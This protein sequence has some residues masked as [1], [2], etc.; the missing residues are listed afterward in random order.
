MVRYEKVR[1]FIKREY[2]NISKFAQGNPDA[3]PL[4]EKKLKIAIICCEKTL[5]DIITYGEE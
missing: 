3:L 2:R 4:F 1:N 5:G